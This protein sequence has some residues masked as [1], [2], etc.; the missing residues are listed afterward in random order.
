MLMQSPLFFV[1]DKHAR[2]LGFLFQHPM[3]HVLYLCV[4]L[5]AAK[6]LLDFL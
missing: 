5:S 3:I 1:Y 2:R 6:E 4:I